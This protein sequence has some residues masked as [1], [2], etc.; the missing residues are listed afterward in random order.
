MMITA[1]PDLGSTH[2]GESRFPTT[3]MY[4]Y[5]LYNNKIEKELYTVPLDMLRRFFSE[6]RPLSDVGLYNVTFYTDAVCVVKFV[7]DSSICIP[8]SNAHLDRPFPSHWW[9]HVR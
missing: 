8:S 5:Y 1:L 7:L 4:Q 3:C 9:L 2:T 6:N